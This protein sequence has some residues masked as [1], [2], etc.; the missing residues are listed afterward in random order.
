MYF[1]SSNAFAH[2]VYHSSLRVISYWTTKLVI[3]R[4]GHK[5]STGQRISNH[6]LLPQLPT[7]ITRHGFVRNR[8]N[9]LFRTSSTL[10]NTLGLPNNKL[11]VK[12]A[13]ITTGLDVLWTAIYCIY[14]EQPVP[15]PEMLRTTVKVRQK[16]RSR[17]EN[18]IKIQEK[19]PRAV[20]KLAQLTVFL[21]S[22]LQIWFHWKKVSA[23]LATTQ[24]LYK[25]RLRSGYRP[26]IKSNL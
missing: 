9:G 23:R 25:N 5:N 21:L 10:N 2:Y 7:T 19:N 16:T 13:S 14:C 3:E 1:S 8:N 12:I 26:G 24:S 17:P 11:A 15:L 22:L 6:W 18:W 4:L 20:P